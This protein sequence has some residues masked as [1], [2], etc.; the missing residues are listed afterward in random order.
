MLKSIAILKKVYAGVKIHVFC[1]LL[2]ILAI[3]YLILYLS[4]CY[5]IYVYDIAEGMSEIAGEE[6]ANGLRRGVLPN[7][8][9]KSMISLLLLISLRVL[10][11]KLDSIGYT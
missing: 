10:K 5:Y 1:E 2:N 7:E 3:L 8:S 4:I 6:S 9:W 11:K